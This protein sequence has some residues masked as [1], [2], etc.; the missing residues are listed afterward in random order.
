MSRDR[1]T[2]LAASSSVLEQVLTRSK[3]MRLRVEPL[4]RD[5]QGLYTVQVPVL[6]ASAV[7]DMLTHLLREA[8]NKAVRASATCRQQ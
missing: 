2:L 4:P 7:S 8:A 1:H 3:C 5:C 6:R